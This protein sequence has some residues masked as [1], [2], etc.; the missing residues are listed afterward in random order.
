M[1]ERVG[2][3]VGLVLTAGLLVGDSFANQRGGRMNSKEFLSAITSG[4][5]VKVKEYLRQ[6]PALV[7]STDEKGT[8]AVLL[9]VYYR[10]KEIVDLL[11]GTGMEIDIFEA[12][13]TG[14]TGR[15]KELIE[16][17][18]RL[19][20]AYAPDGFY[21][22]GLAIFFG[23][24]ETALL[25][26]TSGA[27]VNMASKNA[28]NVM[29]LHAAAAARQ[30]EVA[31]ILVER[32]GDVNARQQAGFT[33]LHEAAATGQVELA[34]LLIT[35]GANVNAQTDDGKTPLRFALKSK[36]SGMAELLRKHGAVE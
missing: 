15:V 1:N 7:R 31:Q 35:R 17:D 29:P 12:A 28:M 16:K 22:L 5:T 23:H 19:L 2:Q 26:V 18:H 6:D 27:E 32:G 33:P 24:K 25:L 34:S 3:V 36:Q 4:E 13:A 11:L 9:A 8:S 14:R 21:P 20:N 30:L 10:Q